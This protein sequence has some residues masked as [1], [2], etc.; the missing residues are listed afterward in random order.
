[1][2]EWRTLPLSA[3]RFAGVPARLVVAPDRA[4][5]VLQRALAQERL[6]LAV[7]ALTSAECV[8]DAALHHAR[9][10]MVRGASLDAMSHI[11]Q[12]LAEIATRI[13]LARCFVDSTAATAEASRIAMAK[14]AAVAALEEAARTAVQ[15]LGA[16]GCVAPSVVE[17]TQRDAPL[18]A[19]GGG[20]TE[21]MNEII[22]RSLAKETPVP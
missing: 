13:A 21:V 6:N 14:N 3:L 11:R 4:A 12:R 7:M 2:A 15:I 9:T 5:R 1:M 20:T 22:A 8:R 18:I 17:R 10:R 16:A 19:I